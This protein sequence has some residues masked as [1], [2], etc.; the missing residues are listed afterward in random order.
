VQGLTNKES[1]SQLNLS[2]FTVRNHLY[3]MMEQVDAGRRHQA[4]E[5]VRA[6][7]DEPAYYFEL[8]LKHV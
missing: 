3:C 4:V 5:T 7:L 1:A 8:K 2:E 6:Q